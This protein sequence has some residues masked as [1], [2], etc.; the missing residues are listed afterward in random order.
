MDCFFFCGKLFRIG[1]IWK[2]FPFFWRL[3]TWFYQHFQF[4]S[5]NYLEKSVSHGC[6][7]SSNQAIDVMRILLVFLVYMVIYSLCWFLFASQFCVVPWR[8]V[9]GEMFFFRLF[10]VGVCRLVIDRGDEQFKT[11]R[12]PLDAIRSAARYAFDRVS[13]CTFFC[14]PRVGVHYRRV[15]R[16]LVSLVPPCRCTAGRL[17]GLEWLGPRQTSLERRRKSTEINLGMTANFVNKDVSI[18]FIRHQKQRSD[19]ESLTSCVRQK[20]F[21]FFPSQHFGV[22]RV[23]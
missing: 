4:S 6:T 23:L 12:R 9:G 19:I 3:R 20:Y 2:A 10:D 11:R 5:S 13:P 14:L 15:Y 18:V 21:L 22:C 8:R 17:F 1:T 7:V 16:V